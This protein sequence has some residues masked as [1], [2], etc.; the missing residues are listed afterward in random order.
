MS[1]PTLSSNANDRYKRCFYWLAC[2][3]VK[4]ILSQE[5]GTPIDRPKQVYYF[6]IAGAVHREPYRLLLATLAGI[7]CPM[8][9]THVSLKRIHQSSWHHPLCNAHNSPKHQCGVPH[10]LSGSGSSCWVIAETTNL[11][12][13]VRSAARHNP[14]PK[15]P[16]ALFGSGQFRIVQY[17]GSILPVTD[18][19]AVWTHVH[20]EALEVEQQC[21][22]QRHNFCRLRCRFS[23][24]F[25]ALDALATRSK[26]LAQTVFHT[27][28][29][30]PQTPATS[31]NRFPCDCDCTE[32]KYFKVI[33]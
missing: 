33:Y 11:K 6:L 14:A 32:N 21:G 29:F 22:R 19:R 8:W 2:L 30:V 10:F 12:G 25:F 4:L 3:I 24:A 23:K 13:C 27:V 16:T 15:I 28:F 31:A 1:S 5:T 26:K 17:G 20:N 7:A 18:L 9:A